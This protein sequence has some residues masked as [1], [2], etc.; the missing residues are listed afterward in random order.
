MTQLVAM[1]GFYIP[2]KALFEL[3][4]ATLPSPLTYVPCRWGVDTGGATCL[5]LC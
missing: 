4:V 2:N 3:V 5:V 1:A